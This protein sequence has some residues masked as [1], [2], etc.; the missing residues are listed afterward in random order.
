MSLTKNFVEPQYQ[1]L[2]A[3]AKKH[4]IS[5]FDLMANGS[6]NEDPRRTLFKLARY[7]FVAK[8]LSG[9]SAVLEGGS[10]DAF[11]TRLV[12]QEVGHVT[13]VDFDR[14]FIEDA[15]AHANP[16][17]PLTLQVGNMLEGPLSGNF[18]AAYA[19]RAR[20]HP[21]T[22]QCFILAQSLCIDSAGCAGNH[23]YAVN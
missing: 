6:W 10:A 14:V 23:R 12:Q 20:A 17:W 15:Q 16:N 8:M 4:G 11:G 3:V 13:A 2:S 22:R 19:W 18:D 7:K 1:R 21:A 9:R 5:S